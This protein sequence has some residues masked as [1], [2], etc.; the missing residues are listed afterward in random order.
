MDMIAQTTAGRRVLVSG[1]FSSGLLPGWP[2]QHF[3]ASSGE[4]KGVCSLTCKKQAETP[5]DGTQTEGIVPAPF[6]GLH[7]ASL[8]RARL[9]AHRPAWTPA[10]RSPTSH[11]PSCC[12]PQPLLSGGPY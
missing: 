6:L 3:V 12:S 4:V 8:P 11:T 1:C 7:S 9:P 2:P 10:S 5:S